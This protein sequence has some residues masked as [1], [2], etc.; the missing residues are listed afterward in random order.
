MQLKDELFLSKPKRKWTFLPVIDRYMFQEFLIPFSVL[1]L[2]FMVLFVIA[3][4]YDDIKDFLENSATN[5]TMVK[6]F[7]LRL[8]GHVEFI[9]PLS[10]LLACMY[11]MAHMGKNMEIIAMRASGIS[12]HRACASIY[13]I[14]ILITFVDFMFKEVVVPD[15][16][17][18]AYILKKTTTRDDY[19][20]N[21][22]RML[23]YR[24]PDGTKTWFFKCFVKEEGEEVVQKGVIL[25]K[26]L[27]KEGALDWDI[28]AEEAEYIPDK[29]W[30]F[31][32]AV[33]T[34]YG[35]DGL[36][37]EK[38]QKIDMIFKD[39]SEFPETPEGIM[40]AVLPPEELPS[41]VIVDL[42]LNTKNMAK[43]SRN[44]Y[45]TTLYNRLAFPWACVLAVF[46]GI[47][48][49][50]R[51]ERSGIFMAIIIAVAIIVAYTL[52]SQ[53]M[54][55]LGNRG[56]VPPMIAGIGPTVVFLG[57]GLYNAVT[58]H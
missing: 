58:H 27:S 25:K 13:F 40:N 16:E 19:T 39:S 32:R 52:V 54:L 4:V 5:M 42:I 41:L 22:R 38:P 7:F 23:T 21:Q 53:F 2:G 11:T 49:A 44:I 1:I 20:H 26:Y 34:K 28:E 3:D 31:R 9:L 47:P 57:Y 8:P 15:S 33:L 35:E 50:S 48:L 51:N 12:L 55:I 6:Y 30:E 10:I 37:P 14:A 36:M 56:Y 43:K 18:K 17:K 24:S 45:E 29:G 46:L